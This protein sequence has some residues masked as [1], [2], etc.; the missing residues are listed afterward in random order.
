[1]AAGTRSATPAR[2]VSSMVISMVVAVAVGGV[3]GLLLW[4]HGRRVR[5]VGQRT[6][7]L[8]R[9][10]RAAVLVAL[11]LTVVGSVSRFGAAITPTPSC[12]D[13]DYLAPVISEPENDG[14]FPSLAAKIATWVPTGLALLY[15]ELR[16]GQVCEYTPRDYYVAAKSDNLMPDVAVN[17]G[18]V[19]LAAP[20]SSYPHT[21]SLAEHESRH[22]SQWAWFTVA[23]GPF[24]FPVAYWI[25]EFF[26]PGS[27]NHFERAAGLADGN[28]RPTGTGPVLGWPQIS[29]LALLGAT[30]VTLLVRRRTRRRDDVPGSSFS[31]AGSSRHATGGGCPPPGRQRP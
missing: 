30:T 23:A 27:R 9:V 21:R 3:F 12:A 11:A 28:Y 20:V 2:R 24:A 1:M 13:P 19:V 10:R 16:G 8:P 26:F 15:T 17:V 18:D 6:G 4:W 22:R 7:R 25:D 14:S 29:V 31:P 5:R